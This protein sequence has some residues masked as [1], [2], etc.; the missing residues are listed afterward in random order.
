MLK[1]NK[2]RHSEPYRKFCREEATRERF[3]A[4]KRKMNKC[5]YL[6]SQINKSDNKF[7][8]IIID[9]GCM[10][11][12]CSKCPQMFLCHNRVK[13]GMAQKPDD[14]NDAYI[15]GDV[16]NKNEHALKDIAPELIKITHEF[17]KSKTNKYDKFIDNKE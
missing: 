7:M 13:T 14:F 8:C 17:I 1:K 3:C 12:G 11:H 16:A 9:L 6:G 10:S 2:P 15:A 5:I 4:I